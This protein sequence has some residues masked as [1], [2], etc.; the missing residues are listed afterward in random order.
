[1][2][3]PRSCTFVPS[4]QRVREFKGQLAIAAQAVV[5]GLQREVARAGHAAWI[6]GVASTMHA[7]IQ[8]CDTSRLV[9]LAV[10]LGPC[11]TRP[12]AAEA[13]PETRTRL[14]AGTRRSPD[15]SVDVGLDIVRTA[16][17]IRRALSD[18]IL[19]LDVYPTLKVCEG[20]AVASC[21]SADDLEAREELGEREGSAGVERLGEGTYG[22]GGRWAASRRPEIAS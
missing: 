15:D 8:P 19:L 18:A 9:P 1:M 14:A 13:L 21:G 2:L 10:A 16:L 20:L 11:C 17:T 7:L 5:V 3:S 6:T 22:G 4:A 12:A